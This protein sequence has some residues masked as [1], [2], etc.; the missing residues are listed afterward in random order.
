LQCR[1]TENQICN[2]PGSEGEGDY[3]S[4]ILNQTD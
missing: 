1:Q 4:L 2:K 3:C